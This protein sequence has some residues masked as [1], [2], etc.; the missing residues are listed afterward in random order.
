ML[1]SFTRHRRWVLALTE[2]AFN[3]CN[4]AVEVGLC[5]FGAMA[6]S[7]PDHP[8]CCR[9]A[10]Q[11]TALWGC[12]EYCSSKLKK[13]GLAERRN[14]ILLLALLSFSVSSAFRRPRLG[15]HSGS[16]AR[17]AR[18]SSG[19]TPSRKDSAKGSVE[20]GRSV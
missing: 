8:S 15:R 16:R 13:L 19:C 20:A 12:E 10:L 5:A 6:T 4:P 9:C 18:S 17:S 1:E 7:A 11:V 3:C 2:W 14:W